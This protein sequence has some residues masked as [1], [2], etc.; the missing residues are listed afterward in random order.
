[1]KKKRNMRLNSFSTLQVTSHMQELVKEAMCVKYIH[2]S[3]M[4]LRNL[5]LQPFVL[6][7]KTLDLHQCVHEGFYS[8]SQNMYHLISHRKVISCISGE[9]SSGDNKGLLA[10]AWQKLVKLVGMESAKVDILI[11]LTEYIYNRLIFS[12]VKSCTCFSIIL[13][14]LLCFVAYNCNI[15]CLYA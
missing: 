8:R 7:K 11:L 10:E 6:Y 3:R 5:V 15:L 12:V 4:E 9:E 2:L 13:F 14:F 1:M